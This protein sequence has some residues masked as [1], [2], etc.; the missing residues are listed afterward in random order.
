[1]IRPHQD[2]KTGT[3]YVVATPIG[4]LE[5]ITLRAIRIL[6]EV[7]AIAAEDTRHTRKLLS[8]L[9]ISK[10]MISYYKEKEVSRTEQIISRLRNGENIAL[11]SDAGTP[12]I[13]DPGHIIT[14]R[15]LAAGI[16]IVPIPGPSAIAAALSIAG[17]E[18]DGLL[19]LGFL[20]ARVAARRKLL[21]SLSHQPYAL[22][23]Y[24][25][26]HRLAASLQ[27][28]LQVLGDRQVFWARELTKVHE[29][30]RSSTLSQ[31][32]ASLADRKLKGESVIIIEGA[33][34]RDEIAADDLDSLL[35]WYRE[36][37]DISLKDAVRRVAEDLGLPRSEV[38]K[39]ALTIWKS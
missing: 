30:I 29:E 21:K 38:Y 32:N 22:A 31:V 13:S 23:F 35:A 3:L 17:R 12:G 14:S 8:H 33:P 28:C 39:K 24:E 7:D 19:F 2:K 25:S 27:D 20:P 16:R 34:A 5:D 4:N 15:A 11:V 18:N 6:R 10:P 37:S 9:A 26:P 1:M 36:E